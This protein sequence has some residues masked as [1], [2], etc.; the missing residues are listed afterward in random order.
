MIVTGKRYTARLP[1]RHIQGVLFLTAGFGTRAEPLSFCRPK[2]LLPWK[3]TTLL[4]NLVKQF[5]GIEPECMVFNASRCPELVMKEAESHWRGKTKLLFE[6]RPLGAPGTLAVNSEMFSGTWIISNTDMVL[7][8]PVQKMVEYHHESGSKWTVLTGDF[9]DH[10][11][12]GGLSI[13]GVSRHYLGVSIISSEVTVLAAGDQLG[14]GFFTELKSSAEASSIRINEFYTNTE[15]LDMGEVHFFRK[16]LL[17]RGS[18]I[19]PSARIHDEAILRGFYWIGSSCIIK[20]GALLQNSVMLQGSVLG[21]GE[22]LVDDVLP[23]FSNKEL[24]ID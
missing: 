1:G 7:D 8:I 10:G 13:N 12:Y 11:T 20:R 24:N 15:W 6:A 17:S 4:G 23:W 14:T 19:H 18:Y 22:S 21:S 2:A 3:E 16:H 9:P 5:A